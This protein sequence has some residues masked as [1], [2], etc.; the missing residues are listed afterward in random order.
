MLKNITF[1]FLVLA[2]AG[3][4]QTVNWGSSYFEPKLQS[5]GST[6]LN[7]DNFIFQIGTFAGGV[8]PTVNA[9]NE[10]AAAWRVLDESVYD[11]TFVSFDSS[12]NIDANG[13]SNGTNAASGYDF[14]GQKLYIWVYDGNEPATDGVTEECHQ[15]ALFSGDWTLPNSA[16][17]QDLPLNYRTSPFSDGGPPA[18]IFG[19]LNDV[20][21]PDGGNYTD[22]GGSFELQTH[23][24]CLEAIPEPSGALL[25][26]VGV[27]MTASQ[28]KRTV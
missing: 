19:G 4:A 25:L 26:L 20:H 9:A 2:G 22:T 27:I 15:W 23:D 13:F 1:H 10:L 7:N 17:Q 8:D 5:D 28:R 14:R 11:E 18:P 3:Y 21:A 24:I 6:G 16:T 12:V